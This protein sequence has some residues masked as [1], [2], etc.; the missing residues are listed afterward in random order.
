[1]DIDASFMRCVGICE[2]RGSGVDKVVFEGEFHQLPPPRWEASGHG[3]R[4][5]LFAHKEFRKMDKD[6][7]VHACYLHACLKHVMREEMTNTSLRERF[8]IEEKNSA[9][10]S[11]IIAMALEAGVIKPFDLSQGKRNARYL[12]F[13]A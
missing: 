8:G 9:T 3:F 11:R 4:A 2:E 13:W 5:V 1:M 7:R 12:P 6:D 10:A